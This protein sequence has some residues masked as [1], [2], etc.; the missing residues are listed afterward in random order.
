MCE[1]QVVKYIFEFLL[2]NEQFS[3]LENV[4]Y[5]IQF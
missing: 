5:T 4:I 3:A 1:P 2:H